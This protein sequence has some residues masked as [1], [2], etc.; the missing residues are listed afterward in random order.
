M[1]KN[2]AKPFVYESLV[3]LSEDGS[4]WDIDVAKI[5]LRKHAILAGVLREAAAQLTGREKLGETI[6]IK[7]PAKPRRR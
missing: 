5:P 3:R 7:R 1:P 2:N 4:Q 6:T